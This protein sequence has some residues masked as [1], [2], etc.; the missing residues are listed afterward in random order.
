MSLFVHLYRQPGTDNKISL[1]VLIQYC[2]QTSLSEAILMPLGK[3]FT[4]QPGQKLD[5][6]LVD[7][8]NRA[9]NSGSSSMPSLCIKAITN[10]TIAT[11]I[12][13][14][15]FAKMSSTLST[16]AYTDV[17]DYSGEVAMGLIMATGMNASVAMPISAFSAKKTASITLDT[18]AKSEPRLL[19]NTEWSIRGTSLP[20]RELGLITKWDKK[21]DANT[22]APGFQPLEY[23]TSGRY[24]GELVRIILMDYLMN[25][26]NIVEEDVP[27]SLLQ[28]NAITTEYLSTVVATA[29]SASKLAGQLHVDFPCAPWSTFT[30]TANTAEVLI[31]IAQRVQ[32]RSSRLLAA[33]SIGLLLCS[34]DLA[35]KTSRQPPPR[36]KDMSPHEVTIAVSGAMIEKY[37]MYLATCQETIDALFFSLCRNEDGVERVVLRIVEEGGLRGAA[38]LAA[39]QP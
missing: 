27:P 34:G 8:Y 19:T 29:K 35:L 25:V 10:D 36:K 21:L 38:I 39:G 17:S 2:R 7:G 28:K 31:T 14:T 3:G 9:V 22:A 1:S 15:K 32:I 6:L 30:W 4:M 11:M 20:L 18:A 33:A 5:M 16:H 13:G 26:A 37:P 12:A 24:M 23:M